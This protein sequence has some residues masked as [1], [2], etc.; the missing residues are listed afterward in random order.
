MGAPTSRGSRKSEITTT[1][2]R[3]RA[4]R[5]SMSRAAARSAGGVGASVASGAGYDGELVQP[6]AAGAL[7]PDRG[8]AS[9][10]PVG[11]VEDRAE[12]VARPGGE[13]ADGGGG[14]EREVALLAVGGAEV[15]AG[16][17][18]DDHPGLELAVDDRLAHVRDRR[19]GR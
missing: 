19:C 16:R 10:G 6:S 1:S 14:G 9:A 2:P 11:D 17:A 12:P 8:R 4:T 3:R 7:R 13:E 18:V 15:E 5:R